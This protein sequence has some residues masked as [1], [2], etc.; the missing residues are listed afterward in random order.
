MLG[1][2]S[3]ISIGR[4][5]TLGRFTTVLNLAQ[6]L[7]VSMVTVNLISQLARG[8]IASAV[9]AQAPDFGIRFIFGLL[10]RFNT[11]V[12]GLQQLSRTQQAWVHGGPLL[13][14]LVIFGLAAVL[15]FMTRPSGTSLS[16]IA[17][18]IGFM[19]LLSFLITANPLLRANGYQLVSVWLGIPKLREKAM[20][21]LLGKTRD[22]ESQTALRGYGLACLIFMA[23]VVGG[24]LIYAARWLELEYQGTGVVIFV[25]LLAYL[26]RH[27][28][29]QITARQAARQKQNRG[30]QQR[31]MVRAGGGFGGPGQPPGQP[32]GQRV[33]AMRGQG[34]MGMAA[35]AA[36][37]PTN[38]LIKW[39]LAALFVGV[40]LLPY[41]YE[42]GGP[43]EILPMQ[44]RDLT[45]ELSGIVEEVRFAGGELVTAGELIATIT[46]DEESNQVAATVAEI[47]EQEAKIA[48]LEAPAR[49]EDISLARQQLETAQVRARF[50]AENAERLK[51]AF[52][53]GAISLDE[54]E[55]AKEQRDIDRAQVDVAR[56]ELQRV[57][58][59]AHPQEI[60]A[61]K[62]ELQGLKDRLV[63]TEGQLTK[64]QL[65]MPFDGRIA[66]INLRDRI[67]QF[68]NKGE[69]FAVVENADSVRVQ[70][71]IPQ[72]DVGEIAEGSSARV[73]IWSYPD[74]EF[75]GEVVGIAPAMQSEEYGPVVIV[76][77]VIDNAD[78]ML[79]T[80]M[81]GFGK[82]DG[83]TKP[84]IVA[85]TRAIV[86][87]F[88][89]EF[90]S[91]LP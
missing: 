84:V 5:L 41:R 68:L 72:A 90:W 87:F 17:L 42:S 66:T 49:P 30:R 85:F 43:V 55:K 18:L 61:A 45:V 6:R 25:V 31:A 13:V 21:A 50:S 3:V 67:G 27:F 39:S 62:A 32:G 26:I 7:L 34:N 22:S 88:L 19:A 23:V 69:V 76:T 73:K 58:S 57:S 11:R 38:P 63:F 14:R 65:I 89:I 75:V 83:G 28:K 79:K 82:I 52:D 44:T 35:P 54:F 86:R 47:A 91:W 46:A 40:M 33:A 2:Y 37:K 15:W 12:T 8:V 71:E 59:G 64:T 78:G 70:M 4:L 77:T 20:G 29:K 36:K 24:I 16:S 48:E 81:T 51:G 9:G 80:G 56:A 60:E 1:H 53:S 10:P 74:N